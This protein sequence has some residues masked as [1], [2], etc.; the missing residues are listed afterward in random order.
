MKLAAI[1][2]RPPKGRPEAARIDLRLLI[3]QA[4]ASGAQIIVL[5]EMATTGYVWDSPQELGPLTETAHGPTTAVL[6][7]AARAHH[8]WIVCGYAERFVHPGRVGPAGK[9]L[10]SLFNSA[11]V[12]NPEGELVTSYR[13]MLLYSLD[14]TWASPGWRRVVVPTE[15]GR[16]VP[17]ICMDLNDDGFIEFLAEA[18]ATVH[19]FC[20]NWLL[21]DGVDLHGYWRAR[22]SGWDGWMIAAN[23]WGED[24][25]TRF[26]GRSAIL[27]PGGHV[28]AEAPSE[29]DAVL[30]VDTTH[31][32]R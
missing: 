6:R 28:V 9:P 5:P 11:L 30:V 24:R 20:T 27:A 4:G 26:A 31:H 21:Q 17:S 19:A 7:Q 25:G 29:G 3:D 32:P 8:A 22:L 16:L 12:V 15:H 18:N 10:V 23:T 2:Y 14:K 1:Q 13:K